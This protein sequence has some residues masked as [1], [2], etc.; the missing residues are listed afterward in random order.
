MIRA[1]FARLVSAGKVSVKLVGLHKSL[2]SC[3]VMHVLRMELRRCLSMHA[4]SKPTNNELRIY[5]LHFHMRTHAIF[6]ATSQCANR[7]SGT[8][9][10]Y[11]IN[12]CATPSLKHKRIPCF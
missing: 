3:E 6:Q 5:P 10:M 4:T 11:S 7:C 2:L 12:S 8:T 1:A 9:H